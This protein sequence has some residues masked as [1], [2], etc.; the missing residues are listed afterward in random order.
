[1]ACLKRTGCRE[2]QIA[3]LF[4]PSNGSIQ[5]IQALRTSRRALPSTPNRTT[6]MSLLQT[7]IVISIPL[8][9]PAKA[10]GLISRVIRQTWAAQGGGVP[11]PVQ[12]GYLSG[13][14]PSV[15]FDHANNV[16]VSCTNTQ[17]YVGNS[18]IYIFK[19]TDEGATY[20][21]TL[22][23]SKILP[24]AFLDKA[25]ITT[26]PYNNNVYI[27]WTELD[28]ESGDRYTPCNI[29][30]ASSTN[31]YSTPT[32]VNSNAFAT[33]T[34]S[35]PAAGINANEIYVTWETFRSGST[36]V[37]LISKSTDGG[38]TFGF[39]N[40]VTQIKPFPNFSCS[41]PSLLGKLGICFRVNSFPTIDVCRNSSSPYFGHVYV[42]WADYRNGD[43]DVFLETSTDGG[44]SWGAPVG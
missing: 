36:P 38:K 4:F 26:D 23:T 40:G 10:A 29:L 17:A 22:V 37:I 28:D 14:N 43:G 34:G 11:L 32:Q 39:N 21:P 42:A 31:S 41:R 15:A 33:N 24:T 12:P 19:S 44:V 13:Y 27:S 25:Y 30:F 3:F 18:A 5:V 35:V 9:L 1:M 7:T 16:Y 8:P 20:I 6:T 2:T